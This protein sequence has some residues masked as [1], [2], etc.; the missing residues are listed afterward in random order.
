VKILVLYTQMLWATSKTES[1]YATPPLI[2]WANVG[3]IKDCTLNCD[4]SISFL[5]L[6]S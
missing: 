2:V 4:R 3:D 6:T 1:G 5:V